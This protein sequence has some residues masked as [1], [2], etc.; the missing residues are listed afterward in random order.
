M[1]S[2]NLRTMPINKNDNLISSKSTSQSSKH[3]LMKKFH[4]QKYLNHK[5]RHNGEVG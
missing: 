3:P 1:P 5:F 2:Q 4:M